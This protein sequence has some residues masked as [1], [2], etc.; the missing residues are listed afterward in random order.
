MKAAAA[1]ASKRFSDN[2]LVQAV[3]T[4]RGFRIDQSFKDHQM[5][6]ALLRAY[7]GK[8][9]KITRFFFLKRS[10]GADWFTPVDLGGLYWHIVDLIWIFLFPLFYL[11]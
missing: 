10:F 6:E 3:N 2:R 11:I 8:F 1:A 5:I 7:H 4:P 9:P